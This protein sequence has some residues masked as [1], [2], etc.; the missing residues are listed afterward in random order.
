MFNWGFWADV[1]NFVILAAALIFLCGKLAKRLFRKRREQIAAEL[2]QADK[3]RAAAKNIA[4]EVEKTKKSGEEKCKAL[5]ADAQKDAQ[6]TT[7]AILE[8]G[9]TSVAHT[10]QEIGEYEQQLREQ[11]QTQLQ[12]D[13]ISKTAALTAEVLGGENFHDCRRVL[14]DNDLKQLQ[15]NLRIYPSDQLKIAETGVLDVQ[16]HVAEALAPV[17]QRKLRQLVQ[18]AVAQYDFKG[19]VRMQIHVDPKQIG[20]IR[21]QVGDTVYDGTICHQLEELIRTAPDFD[22]GQESLDQSVS[23]ALKNVNTK[24]DIFQTGTVTQLYDGICRISGLADCMAG[25]MLEFPGGLIGMAQ[26]LE[27]DNVGCVLLGAYEHIQEGDPV[28]RTGRVMSIPVGDAMIGRVVD[29]LGNPVD[30]RGAIHTTE[31][32]PI[33]SPAPSVLDR[34]PVSVPLQTGIKAIDALVPIGRGQRE[35]II[36][37]RQTGKTAIALDTILNQKGKNVICIYVAIGQKES[38]V[39][40][41]VRKLRTSGAMDY[42]VVVCAHASEAAP[43]LYIAPYAGAAIGEYFMYQGKDVLIVYDDLSKQAVAYREL[44]LILQRPPGREAYPGDVFYLHSRLLERAARLSEEA[45]GG[46]MTALPIIETQAGD[47]SA[48]IPTNVISITDGQIF[49]ETDLFH[50]GIRPAVNV[51]LS[52]SRVGG[53]AQLGAMKQ[54]AGKMRMDLAQY[55]EL[56][57]FAQFGSDLD[58]ATRDALRRGERMTEL[59]KQNQFHPMDATDQVI[60][61]Y[62][63]SQGFADLLPVSEM[64]RYESDLISFVRRSYP[65]LHTEVHSGKKLTK[66]SMEKLRGLIAEF[67]ERFS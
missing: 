1:F 36:G 20:G 42:S 56:A 38:T 52:V 67:T 57:S 4:D 30:G 6:N 17:Q 66:E 37:D 9:R 18:D 40:A 12:H 48:Y 19:E 58:K 8:D 62:A 53:A 54:V 43:M 63:A 7:E 14:A 25:E 47:I 13:M 64:A 60:I 61:I 28:R 3:D 5:I 49:L 46:S 26:D 29:A 16:V 59:L 23:E 22:A 55:R 11:M 31:T 32:R 65:E 45:G 41:V 51:G 24:L 2:S 15:E 21:V 27:R 35:L 50:S 34:Q 10:L 33:E 44:S 39:A